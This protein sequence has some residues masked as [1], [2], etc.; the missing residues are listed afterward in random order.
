[1]VC[2][3]RGYE[4]YVVAMRSTREDVCVKVVFGCEWCV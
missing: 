4:R 2:G 3:D 1:M